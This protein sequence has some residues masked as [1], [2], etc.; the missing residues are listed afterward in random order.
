MSALAAA[1]GALLERKSQVELW[2]Q[3]V[4]TWKLKTINGL[5]HFELAAAIGALLE[6]KS[7]V[8]LWCQT[9]QTWKLK[10]INGLTHFELHFSEHFFM[11]LM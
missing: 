11:V 6:R 9:V 8:E 2:C 4:Q 7:Q 1:I 10:T 3:T 5:T